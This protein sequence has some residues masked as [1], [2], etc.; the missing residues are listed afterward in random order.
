MHE[1][2]HR[3]SKQHRQ[4]RQKRSAHLGHWLL[5]RMSWR[6]CDKVW[7]FRP[8]EEGRKMGTN[9][10]NIQQHALIYADRTSVMDGDGWGSK[11]IA[12]LS[13]TALPFGNQ[14]F[15]FP[16]GMTEPEIPLTDLNLRI[17]ALVLVFLASIIGVG[18]T[19]MGYLASVTANGE[20][21]D[22]L[23]ILRAFTA[24][25][26]LTQVTLTLGQRSTLIR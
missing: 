15:S 16:S 10:S 20:Y 26:C 19:S 9:W 5:L 11:R 23:Y 4:H 18:P 6:L 2:L 22:S 17:F 8:G 24:G 21:S 25:Y 3:A 13:D 7:A 14:S 1:S 12:N